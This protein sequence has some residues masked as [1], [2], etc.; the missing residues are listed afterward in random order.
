[1]RCSSV[2]RNLFCLFRGS[3]SYKAEP[4]VDCHTCSWV[5]SFLT[6]WRM[7][8]VLTSVLECNTWYLAF[9][10][11]PASPLLVSLSLASLVLEYYYQLLY[12]YPMVAIE[13]LILFYLPFLLFL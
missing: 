10:D 12:S 1:M 7:C 11:F 3:V 9:L 13:E 6:E 8:F 4:R 5:R 2:V